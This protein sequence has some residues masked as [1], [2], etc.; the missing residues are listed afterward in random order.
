MTDV[1][2]RRRRGQCREVAMITLPD[3]ASWRAQTHSTREGALGK[4]HLSSHIHLRRVRSI[5]L[6]RDVALSTRAIEPLW[7]FRK[8]ATE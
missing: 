8:E 1:R 5:G 4:R 2:T 3:L 7:E 6:N